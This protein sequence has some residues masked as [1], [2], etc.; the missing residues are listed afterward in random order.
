MIFV[1]LDGFIDIYEYDD[2]YAILPSFMFIHVTA[3][4]KNW[5]YSH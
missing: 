2:M 1:V 5:T 4:E 3:F